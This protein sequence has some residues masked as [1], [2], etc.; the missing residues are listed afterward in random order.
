MYYHNIYR[1]YMS[2]FSEK[3]YFRDKC[4]TFEDTKN[5]KRNNRSKVQQT[6]IL[7]FKILIIWHLY[8]S[9]L[10]TNSICVW[11]IEILKRRSIVFTSSQSQKKILFEEFTLSVSTFY[12]PSAKKC[13]DLHFLVFQYVSL[14]C[15]LFWYPCL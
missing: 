7:L 3:Y 1:M 9:T 2:A 6:S 11:C 5:R 13:V 14:L 15:Q 8:G 10:N 4:S 12:I